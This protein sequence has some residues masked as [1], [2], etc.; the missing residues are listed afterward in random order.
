MKFA[1]RGGLGAAFPLL[2]MLLL[3]ML[4][5]WLART[6]GLAGF[7]EPPAATNDPDYIVERFSLT[8]LNESGVPRYVLSADKLIHLPHDDTSLL[9]RPNLRQLQGDRPEVRTRSRR[10]VVTA[11]GE[12]AHLHDDVEVFRAGEPAAAGREATE[13]IRVTTSYLRVLPD[14][15]RADTHEKVRI[16]QG[17]SVLVGT[18][19][20]FDDRYRRFQLRSTVQASFAPRRAAATANPGATR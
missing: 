4:T 20:D 2:I 17:K 14:A 5:L 19:M 16:E 8:R 9:T 3:A 13:A 11:G 15:D 6:I 10:G 12:V 7:D 1:P 18:G